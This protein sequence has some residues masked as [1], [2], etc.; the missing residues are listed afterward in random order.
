[1]SDDTHIARTDPVDGKSLCGLEL[2]FKRFKGGAHQEYGTLGYYRWRDQFGDPDRH[3]VEWCTNCLVVLCATCHG[4]GRAY[5]PVGCPLRCW[6]EAAPQGEA[7]PRGGTGTKTGIWKQG[8]YAAL[9][10]ESRRYSGNLDS[11][12]AILNDWYGGF[13]AARSRLA[14]LEAEM[15]RDEESK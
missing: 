1:M 4:V 14:A 13:D 6:E 9:M 8:A 5:G 7:G 10:R 3:V 15:I 11:S 12:V 2:Q